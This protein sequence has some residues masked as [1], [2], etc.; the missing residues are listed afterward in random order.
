MQAPNAR[1]KAN[2]ANAI[3]VNSFATFGYYPTTEG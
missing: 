3:K 2:G 1:A